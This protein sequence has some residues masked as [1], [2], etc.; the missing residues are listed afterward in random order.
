[1]S[2]R[3]LNNKE[4]EWNDISK[5][6]N[7]EQPHATDEE[8]MRSFWRKWNEIITKEDAKEE[9][10]DMTITRQEIMDFLYHEAELL[11]EWKLEE[12]AA[13]FSD[14]GKYLIPPLGNPDADPAKS[15]LLYRR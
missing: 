13:L 4:V 5:G 14:D 9:V 3:L 8:Q 7:R 6:M 2:G 12:W 15:I 10:L 11:D 1:M